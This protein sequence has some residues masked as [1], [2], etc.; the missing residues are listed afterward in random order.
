LKQLNN[1]KTNK[2]IKKTID[3]PDDLLLK[4]TKIA[5][6]EDRSFSAQVRVLLTE[7]TNNVK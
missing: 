2:M 7:S 1:I 6:L 3:F 5:K 4:I